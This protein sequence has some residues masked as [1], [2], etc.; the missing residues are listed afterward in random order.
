MQQSHC[1]AGLENIFKN[2]SAVSLSNT[3]IVKSQIAFIAPVQNTEI[4]SVKSGV[5]LKK[6]N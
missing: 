3:C 5:H 6:V 4:I 2:S 1:N